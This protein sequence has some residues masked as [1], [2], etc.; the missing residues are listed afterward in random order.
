MTHAPQSAQAFSE[1]V[2]VLADVR[3]R[4]VLDSTRSPDELDA[5]DGF[6]YVLQLR[7]GGVRAVRRG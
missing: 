1:L 6:R 5:L 4:Y 7:V 2:D 3:D